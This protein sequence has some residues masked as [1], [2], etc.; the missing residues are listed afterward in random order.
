MIWV[1][2]MLSAVV[3][4]AA[5]VF[6]TMSGVVAAT[7]VPSDSVANPAAEVTPAV[8]SISTHGTAAISG[9]NLDGRGVDQQK[10]KV[11]QS[12][13]ALASGFIIDPSATQSSLNL[14]GIRDDVAIGNDI[15]VTTEHM[16]K[17][18]SDEIILA[19]KGHASDPK[20]DATVQSHS[21]RGCDCWGGSPWG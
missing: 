20:R 6:T 14:F 13:A 1:Q 21:R 12:F 19:R 17:L 8:V 2:K 4:S 16:A 5:L 11:P 3:G 15:A 18:P 9:D 7:N 10:R